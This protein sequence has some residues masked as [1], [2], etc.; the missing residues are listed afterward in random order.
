MLGLRLIQRHGVTLLGVSRQGRRFRERVRTCRSRPATCC[1]CSAPDK[2]IAAASQW[3]GVL[4]LENRRLE[5]MQRTKAFLAIASSPPRSPFPWRDYLA[6]RS[7]SGSALSPMCCWASSAAREVYEAVEWKVIVLLAS[8]DPAR[9][10]RWRRPAARADRRPSSP[11]ENL[12][13][14]VVLMC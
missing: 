5:L 4:P 1:C 14:W 12:P 3:L 8:S 13:A 11:T 9:Q 10:A 6:R 7:R 2:N